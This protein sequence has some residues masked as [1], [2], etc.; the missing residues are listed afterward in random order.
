M[1]RRSLCP[2]GNWSQWWIPPTSSWTAGTSRDGTWQTP[3][4]PHECWSTTC[5]D[6]WLHTWRK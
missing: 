3:W 4:K 5:N 2:W 6:K 1:G